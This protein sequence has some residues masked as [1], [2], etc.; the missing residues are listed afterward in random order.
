MNWPDMI[1]VITALVTLAGSYLLARQ[2]AHNTMQQYREG[3]KLRDG[4]DAADK[5]ATAASKMA[6]QYERAQAKILELTSALEKEKN[7]G[8]TRYESVLER[9]GAMARN[10]Q[11]VSKRVRLLDNKVQI[12]L[13]NREANV[14]ELIRL[15]G[16]EIKLPTLE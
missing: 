10:Y 9:L 4:G 7:D 15:G 14:K 16:T 13:A 12:I 5:F 1:P 3:G 6:E 2:G 11:E 8:I